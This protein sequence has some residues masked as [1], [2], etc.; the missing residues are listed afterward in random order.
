[1]TAAGVAGAGGGRNAGWEKRCDMR[2]NSKFHVVNLAGDFIDHFWAVT[3]GWL[4]CPIAELELEPEPE[5][6]GRRKRGT[7]RRQ[8]VAQGP[9]VQRLNGTRSCFAVAVVV[10]AVCRSGNGDW[11]RPLA[12]ACENI[13]QGKR[14]KKDKSPCETRNTIPAET[15]PH[16]PSNS[17][18]RGNT[19]SYPCAS[20][21]VPRW[22]RAWTPIEWFR[23]AQLSKSSDA[24]GSAQRRDRWAWLRSCQGKSRSL[25]HIH[26]HIHL[27]ISIQLYLLLLPLH[28]VGSVGGAPSVLLKAIHPLLWYLLLYIIECKIVWKT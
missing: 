2:N 25:I 17:L 28:V 21:C 13:F 14:H 16:P 6:N 20:F 23:G 5:L 4:I 22:C 27:R 11:G 12:A 18:I 24:Y 19:F 1:M 15:P 7:S 9:R 3:T 26:I 10:A 8:A